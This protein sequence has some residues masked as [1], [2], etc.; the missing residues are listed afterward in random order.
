MSPPEP[1]QTGPPGGWPPLASSPP[2]VPSAQSC[3]TRPRNATH[4]QR[5]SSSRGW[6]LVE[7]VP[8][9]TAVPNSSSLRSALPMP[10]VVEPSFHCP[11]HS[12]H[13]SAPLPGAEPL[14]PPP[15][16]PVPSVPLS[17]R[18]VGVVQ[19]PSAAGA[20]TPPRTEG[21]K[22][23][24]WGEEGS[25]HLFACTLTSQA[26]PGRKA[27]SSP[28][29]AQGSPGALRARSQGGRHPEAYP[30]QRGQQGSQDPAS[31][32]AEAPAGT[33]GGRVSAVAG[34]RVA[35]STAGG[36]FGEGESGEELASRPAAR[37]R[38]SSRRGAWL[39]R[40]P[41]RRGLTLALLSLGFFFVCETGPSVALGRAV[42]QRLQ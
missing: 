33:E 31:S 3:L 34:R 35:A 11:L 10:L 37:V 7:P 32:R 1:S 9:P 27:R 40:R 19:E 26:Q 36:G 2:S 5:I 29:P 42:W 39:L 30:Q 6:G 25:L 28:S 12:A 15:T 23:G 22:L 21:E 38:F 8:V 14:S 17:L 24:E 20:P 18:D 16:P 13:R 41:S 4:R